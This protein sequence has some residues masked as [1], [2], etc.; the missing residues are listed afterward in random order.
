ML[1]LKERNSLCLDNYSL[2]IFP[3]FLFPMHLTYRDK[4][5]IAFEIKKIVF[6]DTVLTQTA[7]I[8]KCLQW[9]NVCS[10]LPAFVTIISVPSWSNCC[11]SLQVSSWTLILATWGALPHGPVFSGRTAESTEQVCIN[12][13][14]RKEDEKDKRWPYHTACTIYDN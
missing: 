7:D 4:I 9:R 11:Q 14:T 6:K 10:N 8:R 5:F 1:I 12:F 13:E 3:L 2:N